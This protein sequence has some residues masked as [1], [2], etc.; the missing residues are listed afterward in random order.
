MAELGS[1]FDHVEVLPVPIPHDCVD[2]FLGAYWRRLRS[3]SVQRFATE[4]PVSP[5][6]WTCL[7]SGVLKTTWT[8]VIGSGAMATFLGRMSSTL[9]TG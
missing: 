1:V 4:S 3:T 6:V 9:V 5:H 2:G 8:A 7:H